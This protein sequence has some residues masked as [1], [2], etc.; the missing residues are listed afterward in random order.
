MEPEILLKSANFR[1]ISLLCA[2]ENLIPFAG[3]VPGPVFLNE[4]MSPD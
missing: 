4:L 1:G 3:N 2:E